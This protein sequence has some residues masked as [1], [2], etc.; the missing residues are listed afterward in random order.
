LLRT[1]TIVPSVFICPSTDGVPD[2]PPSGHSNFTDLSQNLSYSYANPYPDNTALASGYRP[3]LSARSVGFVI[4]G[5]K[6][7]GKSRGA[8]VL[9][10]TPSSPRGQLMRANSWNHGQA[11]QNLLFLDGHVEFDFSVFSGANQDNVYARG[12]GGPG[13]GDDAIVNSPKDSADSV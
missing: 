1:G 6:N 2:G 11:G 8:D 9:S 7:P 10:V 12:M 3:R 4:A 13:A 5:D